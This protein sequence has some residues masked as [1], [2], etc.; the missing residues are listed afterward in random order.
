MSSN[1]F[2]ESISIFLNFLF[3]IC[4]FFV[5]KKTIKRN[6]TK[7]QFNQIVIQTISFTKIWWIFFLS[8]IITLVIWFVD[9]TTK[10]NNR[11]W[12]F[13]STNKK[14]FDKIEHE[15]NKCTRI[16]MKNNEKY[17]NKNFETYYLKR[18]IRREFI[19]VE[20]FQIND[21]TKRLN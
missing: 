21:Y 1:W 19:I 16:R 14:V 15:Y 4:I 8:I 3:Q 9:Y 2:I 6:F 7:R 20:N 5:K 11:T 13:L 18:N 10:F 12:K 17:I